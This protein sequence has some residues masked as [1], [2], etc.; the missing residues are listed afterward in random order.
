VWGGRSVCVCE[1]KRSLR[2]PW[3]EGR[4]RPWTRPSRAVRRRR[5]AHR[6]APLRTLGCVHTRPASPDTS[7]QMCLP[8]PQREGGRG[9]LRRDQSAWVLLFAGRACERNVAVGKA[10]GPAALAR[11]SARRFAPRHAS[12]PIHSLHQGRLR[13]CA[14]F[15]TTHKKPATALTFSR[16]LDSANVFLAPLERRRKLSRFRHHGLAPG[17]ARRLEGWVHVQVELL[18][19]LLWREWE[20]VGRAGVSGIRRRRKKTGLTCGARRRGR[21]LF[22]VSLCSPHEPPPSLTTHPLREATPAGTHGWWWAVLT[23]EM[24]VGPRG[25]FL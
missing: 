13:V 2:R 12:F 7:L 21:A 15:M 10:G 17:V 3:K 25:G 16:H 14:R 6:P 9:T 20:G 1:P 23:E 5:R 4:P 22:F 24:E 8:R 11:L 18:A 19:G